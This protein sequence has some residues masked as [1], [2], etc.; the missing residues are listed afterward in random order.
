MKKPTFSEGVLV[1]FCLA[2]ISVLVHTTASI[3]F[4]TGIAE[5]IVVSVSTALYAGYLVYRSGEKTGRLVCAVCVTVLIVL[6]WLLNMTFLLVPAVLIFSVW[7]IRTLYFHNSTLSSIAD[8]VLQGFAGGLALW[9][10]FQTGSTFIIV[11]S[12]FL[13]QALFVLIRNPYGKARH[14][15][16]QNPTQRNSELFDTAHHQAEQSFEKLIARKSG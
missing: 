14:S 1:A 7:I 4:R 3:L 6:S 15:A 10:S 2:L 8:L 11:W 9:A 12:F 5:M 13:V 16:V